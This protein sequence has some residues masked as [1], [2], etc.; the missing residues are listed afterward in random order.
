MGAYAISLSLSI[1]SPL[2]YGGKEGWAPAAY[3]RKMQDGVMAGNQATETNK[4]VVHGQVEIIGNLME[5]SNLLNKKPANE[6]H[7]HT[8]PD[9]NVH[10]N[11]NTLMHLANT[12]M[13]SQTDTYTQYNCNAEQTDAYSNNTHNARNSSSSSSSIN[14]AANTGSSSSERDSDDQVNQHTDSSM[15]LSVSESSVSVSVPVPDACVPASV[16]E[17]NVSSTP[18]ALKTKSVPPSPAIA[19]VAPQRFHSVETS[20]IFSFPFLCFFFF[21]FISFPFSLYFS[22]PFFLFFFL[23][24]IMLFFYVSKIVNTFSFL[25]VFSLIQDHHQT[26]KNH[27]PVEKTAWSVYFPFLYV[28][29][30]LSLH[31]T[32]HTQIGHFV[33]CIMLN[34]KFFFSRSGISVTAAPRSP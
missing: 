29:F 7:S 2:S 21:L 25:F 27:F 6:R 28:S 33:V 8:E 15:H 4:P 1:F 26:V 10:L 23:L 16:S 19:R 17:A 34:S 31:C 30:P 3:L 12:Y 5:I 22:F 13:H 11:S 20:E 9:T 18:S 32:Q 24:S 14:T